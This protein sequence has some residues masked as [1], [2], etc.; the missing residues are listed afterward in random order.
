MSKYA[1]AVFG[2]LPYILAMN[3][4]VK[5]M[6]SLNLFPPP[7]K[8]AETTPNSA[9]YAVGDAFRAVG[10]NLRAVMYEEAVK[11][12]RPAPKQQR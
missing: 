8:E 7:N 4:F 2:N 12:S 10:N 6:G 1:L 9:W 5:G 3:S 11:I